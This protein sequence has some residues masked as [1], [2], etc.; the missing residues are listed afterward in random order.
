MT[1]WFIRRA[2]RLGFASPAYL[3]HFPS[4]AFGF[5]SSPRSH[6]RQHGESWGLL[7][8]QG[9]PA[10][11]GTAASVRDRRARTG[12]G[13]CTAQRAASPAGRQGCCWSVWGIPGGPAGVLPRCSCVPRG[14]CVKGQCLASC[15]TASPNLPL[16]AKVRQRVG[17]PKPCR[18]THG[19]Q[20]SQAHGLSSVPHYFCSQGMAARG[21]QVCLEG[22]R[23]ENM[24]YLPQSRHSVCRGARVGAQQHGGAPFKRRA[25]SGLGGT[26]R[27]PVLT[28]GYTH[29]ILLGF[30]LPARAQ[31]PVSAHLAGYRVLLSQGLSPAGIQSWSHAPRGSRGTWP[32]ELSQQK[33][34]WK[35]RAGW[36]CSEVTLSRQGQEN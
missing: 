17:L 12:A 24:S 4:A 32:G 31:H 19:R 29:P 26:H 1:F 21:T 13:V 33:T 22:R 30:P 23:N 10:P 9:L 7:L 34:E 14:G 18:N 27:Q 20:P 6:G 15:P 16:T 2:E 3:K 11:Q 35:G 5:P 25:P 28:P 36:V 8:A